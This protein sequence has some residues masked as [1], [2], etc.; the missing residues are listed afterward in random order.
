V[1]D[2]Q[3]LSDIKRALLELR[4]EQERTRQAARHRIRPVD[5]TGRLPLSFAQ[6]RLWFLDQWAPGQEV[7]NVAFGLRLRGHLDVAAMEAALDELVVR[8]EVLRTT[9]ES[10]GGVPYQLIHAPRRHRLDARDL[11]SLTEAARE[12][13]LERLA[14]QEARRPFDLA[15]ESMFRPSL[16]RMGADDHVLFVCLHHI[17]SDGWSIGILL[18]ELMELYGAFSEGRPS[19]LEPLEIQYG[20]FAAWQQEWLSGDT[21]DELTR[22]WAKQLEGLATLDLPADRPRPAN[23]TYEGATAR[24][25]LSGQLGRALRELAR[26][27]QTSLFNVLLAGFQAL[28]HRYTGQYD[29]VVGSGFAGRS[30]AQIEPLVGFFVNMLVMRTDL[31][32]DPTVRELLRRVREMALDATTHQDMPFERLVDELKPER[33]PSRNPLFQVSVTMQTGTNI[34][35]GFRLPGLEIDLVP[36]GLGTSRF[37]VALSLGEGDGGVVYCDFEYSTL[38]FDPSRMERMLAHYERLLAGMVADPDRRVSELPVLTDGEWAALRTWNRTE[39]PYPAELTIPDLFEAQVAARPHAVAVSFEGQELTYRELDRRANQLAHRLRRLGVGPDVIVGVCLARSLELVVSLLGVLK[40]GGAYVPLDHR[41]PTNRLAYLLDDTAT[42]VVITTSELAGRLPQGRVPLVQLDREDLGREPDRPPERSIDPRGLAYTIYTSG[43]TGRP[44]G[45]LVEHRSVVQFAESTRRLFEITPADRFLQFAAFTFDVSVFEIFTSLTSGCRLC[46][47]SQDRL[48]DLD[49]LAEL[50]ERERVTVMDMA[51]AVMALLD[52]SR[53]PDLRILFVGGEAFTGELTNRWNLGDRRFFNG[54][55]PTETTVTVIAY[56]CEHQ[57]WRSTPPI[58]RAMANHQAHVVDRDGNAVPVGVPGE[59]CIGGV[60]LA[61]GYLGSP[62]LTADRFV[63]DRFGDAGGRLYRSG[64][65][66]VW[67]P[68]GQIEFLGRIDDQVKIRGL[69]VELE[70]IEA[71]IGAHPRVRQAAVAVHE[72]QPGNRRLV[73][74]IVSEA[75]EPVSQGDLREH[76]AR[77][78]PD[79]MIPSTFVALDAL[80][81]TSSGKVNRRALPEPDGRGLDSEYVAP[82]TETE[83]LLAKQIFGSVLGVEQVGVQDSFFDLGG[84]SLQATQVVSR[85]RETFNADVNLR[86]LYTA[87]S[88]E[89]LAKLIQEVQ[90]G[91]EADDPLRQQLEDEIANLSDEEALRLLEASRE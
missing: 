13:E 14:E 47:M 66:G 44:K 30:R 45:V 16:V 8:H 91:A 34:R 36:M 23:P 41:Y 22:Y 84:N 17:A 72:P 19:P 33:D 46:L 74:Y 83:E 87:S 57:A 3:N 64:D 69:R 37:D 82:R 38:L 25:V 65:L 62:G 42:P 39:A 10:E 52:G 26:R 53:F 63:P 85:I 31:G 4:L 90:D 24:R 32:G 88:V 40:A 68:D 78:V 21:M 48:L 56:E 50:I 80:P 73:A 54:Y 6:Q 76:L 5:R 43:S 71:V 2:P 55:G 59:I 61:R 60:G 1:S 49:R 70:E 12:A 81:L 35:G 58:G 79:Y 9:F 28:L 20:D 27:E 89:S 86:T 51:P 18:G 7:Y 11:G 15:R 29:I 75:G 67:R 77:E